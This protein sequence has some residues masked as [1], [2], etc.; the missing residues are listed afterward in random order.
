MPVSPM[1]LLYCETFFVSKLWYHASLAVCLPVLCC[2]P[3]SH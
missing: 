3:S 2:E 1:A